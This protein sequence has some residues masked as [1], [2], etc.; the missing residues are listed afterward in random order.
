MGKGKYNPLY[1]TEMCRNWSEMGHC[2]YGRTCQFAHGRTELRQVPRHNQ[3][4]T[5]TCGA[6]LNGTCS[7]GHRCCY[8]REWPVVTFHRPGLNVSGS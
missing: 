4:K 1:K 5:K 7:Y 2:R 3:W 6:W 8:A